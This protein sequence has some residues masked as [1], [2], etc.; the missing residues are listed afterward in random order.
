LDGGQDRQIK[1]KI[2]DSH[3][4]DSDNWDIQV[5]AKQRKK[6]FP[7]TVQSLSTLDFS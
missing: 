6:P 2:K 4:A 5:K 7:K 1:K 3:N